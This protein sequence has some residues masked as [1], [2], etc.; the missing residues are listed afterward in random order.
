M[1]NAS[2]ELTSALQE[3]FV[4]EKAA[5]PQIYRANGGDQEPAGSHLA[6]SGQLDS[7]L[8]QRKAYLE[9]SKDVSI[10]RY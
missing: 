10:G 8:E 6:M 7:F 5:A 9:S 1:E 2:K 4:H 3:L